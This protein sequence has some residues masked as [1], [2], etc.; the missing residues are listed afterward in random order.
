VLTYPLVGNYEVP[1][2]RLVDSLEV[3]F[4]S[5]RAQIAGLIVSEVSSNYNH[6][7]AA[8]SLHDWLYEQEVQALAGVDTER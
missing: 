7:T 1:S 2:S 5:E 8:T 6:W 3:A 4:E